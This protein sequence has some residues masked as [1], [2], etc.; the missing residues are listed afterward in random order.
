M[1]M[2]TSI[3]DARVLICALVLGLLCGNVV[4]DEQAVLKR[5]REKFPQ[6]SVE[7]VF[8]TPYPGMYEVLMDS[9]LFYTDEQVSYVLIGNLIDLESGQ[10]LTRQRLRE[11]TAIDWKELPL[12]LAIKKVK[13]DGSRQ[14]ALFS[15]PLCSHCVTQEKEFAKLDNV[16]IYT[17]VYP[18]ER[19]H[20][21]ATALS[22]AVWCSSDPVKAWDDFMLNSAT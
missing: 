2:W 13:G 16:T 9:K 8:R 18:I 1:T 17:F 4:A 12:D 11:L 15:D 20:K 7:K 3:R 22:R 6:S 19:L 10:N 21:G 14:L 5:V